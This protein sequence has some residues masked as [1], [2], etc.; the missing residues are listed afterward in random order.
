M[1]QAFLLLTWFPTAYSSTVLYIKYHV[2]LPSYGNFISD[3][4]VIP[5]TIYPAKCRVLGAM[6]YYKALTSKPKGSPFTSYL[7]MV[8]SYLAF[9]FSFFLRLF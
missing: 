1:P 7:Q 6:F 8:Y 2:N 9:C 3:F 5:T 4:L